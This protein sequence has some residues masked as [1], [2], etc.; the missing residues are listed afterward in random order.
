MTR[1]ARVTVIFA[2]KVLAVDT[3]AT[4]VITRD[5]SV[6]WF[7][8]ILLPGLDPQSL[9][10]FGDRIEILLPATGERATAITKHVDPK[11]SELVFE[12]YGDPPKSFLRF[13]K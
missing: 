2:G 5:E 7:G 4:Y 13:A 9:P 11:T 6:E 8:T 1:S 10:K 12:G 3:E